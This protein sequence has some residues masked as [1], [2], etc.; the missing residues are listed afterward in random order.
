[1]KNKYFYLI[2][3][4]FIIFLFIEVKRL[5]FTPNKIIWSESEKITWK[6]FTPTTSL[7]NNMGATILSSIKCDIYSKPEKLVKHKKTT[8]MLTFV[9]YIIICIISFPFSVA[10]ITNPR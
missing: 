10:R 2:A 9:V 8:N 3:V 7:A 1:M 6:D 4:I 5:F